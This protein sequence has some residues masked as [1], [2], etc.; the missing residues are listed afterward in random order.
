MAAVI[1]TR[2]IKMVGLNMILYIA[3][4][5]AIPRD[6][7][8][9]AR[10]EG[11]SRWQ[12]FRMIIWPLLAPTTLI[13]MVLTTIGSFKVFD[14]IY[15]MTGGGPENGNSR[16][17]L[18]YLSTGVQILQCRICLCA[19]HNHVRDCHGANSCAGDAATQGDEM[20]RRQ[21]NVVYR[22][23]WT[24]AL[25]IAA[26]PFIFPFVWMVSAGFKSTTEIF[27]T[28]TQILR[29]WR[30]QNFV[31]VFTY[32][33]FARQYFNSLYI[34]VAVTALTLVISSLA[35]YALARMRFAG[36]G[37]LMLFFVSALMVPEEVTLPELLPRYVDGFG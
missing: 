15:Q 33:P 28:P 26:I 11:A 22:S 21:I 10:L 1:V 34:A 35:G 29:E 32:Q 4:L 5:Q 24:I 16:T 27:G 3:A 2:V 12:I 31:D 18:L 8:E 7:E 9:A 37:L 13:I 25:L 23:C 14:H 17:R 19:G 20:T 36:A 30:F 6:Y